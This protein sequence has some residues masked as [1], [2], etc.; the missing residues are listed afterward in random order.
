MDS[1]I[2]FGASTLARLA[3]YY[4]IREMGLKVRGFVV[5][6][7]YKNEDQFL[8]LPVYSWSEFESAFE[9]NSVVL[10]IAIGYRTMRARVAAY[11]LVKGAG[12]HLINIVSR[13][14]Y[15]AEDVSLGDNNLIMPGAVLETGVSLGANN[16]VWSNVTVCHDSVVGSHNFL[17]ANT[18]LGGGVSIGNGNFLGFSSV[19]LEGRRIGNETLIG[20]QALV[21]CDTKDLYQYYGTPAT[22]TI[23]IDR[24]MGITLN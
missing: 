22:A 12:Y 15:V 13:A 1:L 16:V 21:R 19:V 20:A 8:S 4:A 6:D 5:N 14:S 10:H 23:A 11:E 24:D 18:T 9:I 17:A 2:I 3:H 7:K